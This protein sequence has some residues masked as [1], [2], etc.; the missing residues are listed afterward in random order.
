[1]GGQMS[2]LKIP[3]K[4][5]KGE[6]EMKDTHPLVI[7]GGG[8]HG[9]SII[10][11]VRVLGKYEIVGI[12]DDEL[13]PGSEVMGVPVLGDAQVLPSLF[14]KGVRSAINAVGGIGDVD[15][16]IRTFERL[17]EQGFN[18]PAIIHPTATVEPSAQLSFGAQIL[19]HA[20]I[21]TKAWIGFG[22]IVNN[23]AIVSH[24]CLI[25]DYASLAPGAMLAGEVK[26]GRAVQIG[27]G[28]TI[29]LR[30]SVGERALIGNSAV[31]KRDVP[32]RTIVR[33]GT[34]WPSSD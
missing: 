15:S 27:M 21:G 1:M 13:A 18:C 28:V 14:S 2:D 32:A 6:S 26:I 29:N 23:G 31:V 34:I 17:Q 11:A 7:Y 4:R 8:G 24:D 9:R 25:E 10:D 12:V 5:Q 30:L 22:V 16:R 19:P 33:A 3:S 20:Y